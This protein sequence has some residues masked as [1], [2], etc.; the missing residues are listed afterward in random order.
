[1]V[2]LEPSVYT[3]TKSGGLTS[4]IKS[5]L[6]YGIAMIRSKAVLPGANA[7]LQITS[8]R[9]VF[10]FYFEVKASGPGGSNNVYSATTSPS[11]FVMV[12]MEEKKRSRELVVGQ[13]NFF[14]AQSGTLDKDTRPFDYVK[15]APG[16]YKVTPRQDLTSG[17]YGIFFGGSVPIAPVEPNPFFPIQTF[18]HFGAPGGSKVFDFGIKLPK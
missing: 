3:Q 6:T 4:L 1:M 12:K 15:L 10:Y 13:R 8:V 16:L 14:G 17:E 2:Q 11:E 7:K 18:G 5:A 9:P